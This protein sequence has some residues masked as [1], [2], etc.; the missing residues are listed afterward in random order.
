MTGGYL[1]KL[2]CGV[3]A[4]VACLLIKT[5]VKLKYSDL[6]YLLGTT[7]PVSS[8]WSVCFS[9]SCWAGQEVITG[10]SGPVSTSV[11]HS[12]FCRAH[13]EQLLPLFLCF[14]AF[15]KNLRRI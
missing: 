2:P 6:Q 5:G 9:G 3:L 11:L 13:G 8:Y 15:V 14:G 10:N 7:S 4:P 12:F 1:L